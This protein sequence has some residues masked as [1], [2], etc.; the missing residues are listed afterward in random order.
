MTIEKK[1][2]N[3]KPT[4]GF[5]GAIATKNEK[6]QQKKIRKQVCKLKNQSYSKWSRKQKHATQKEISHEK[7]APITSK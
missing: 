3:L 4:W 6:S 7:Y 5:K 1:W 2:W